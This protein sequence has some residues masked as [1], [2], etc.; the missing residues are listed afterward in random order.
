MIIDL[1]TGGP[2]QLR[3]DFA[4]IGAGAAGLTLARR[5]VEG[6]RSVILL[7]SGGLDYE[8]ATA[9]LNRGEVSGEPYY[10]LHDARLRFFGG[11]TAIWGGRS[12]E[13]DAIDFE[14]R[15]WVEWSG[16][17]FD[18]DELRPW[19]DKAWRLL[20]PALRTFLRACSTGSTEASSRC[21]TGGSTRS[22]TASER[23]ATAICSTI[24]S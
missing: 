1:G 19:Y 6:G 8:S 2:D 17:P 10:P 16:W 9:D 23:A 20:E 7:E 18:K 12:A 4:V 3:A 15:D 13:L 22:S 24:R 11:T 14:K 21:V 5:L